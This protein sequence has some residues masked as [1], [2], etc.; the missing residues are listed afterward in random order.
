VNP[1]DADTGIL[2]ESIR[3]SKA[4]GKTRIK[5]NIR[6][7]ERRTPEPTIVSREG[8]RYRPLQNDRPVERVQQQ[9]RREPDPRLSVI[10]LCV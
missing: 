9:S 4:P 1:Q 6:I 10:N 2:L 5:R 8:F 3:A 7:R